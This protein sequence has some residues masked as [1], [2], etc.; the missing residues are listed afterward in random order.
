MTYHEQVKPVHNQRTEE[1][2][3][4]RG[5]HPNSQGRADQAKQECGGRGEAD[6]V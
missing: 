6:W 5:V 1:P 4:R 2:T 3:S